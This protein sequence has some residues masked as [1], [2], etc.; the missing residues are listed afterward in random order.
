MNTCPHCFAEHLAEHHFRDA[1][2]LTAEEA[3]Q[4]GYC[5]VL[6][7]SRVRW[8]PTERRLQ[9]AADH[10][11]RTTSAEVEAFEYAEALR[12]ALSA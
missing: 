12:R 7:A 5:P 2:N 3:A 9:V 6:A 11:A 4:L 1:G 8:T 10:Q